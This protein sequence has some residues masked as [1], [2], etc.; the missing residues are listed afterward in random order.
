MD[1]M[2]YYID[3]HQ[4]DQ[5]I[6]IANHIWPYSADCQQSLASAKLRPDVSMPVSV[7]V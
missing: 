3:S 5:N 2:G 6:A 1:P 4:Q 7:V